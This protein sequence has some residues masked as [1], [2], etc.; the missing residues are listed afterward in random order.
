[1]PPLTKLTRA[2]LAAILLGLSA[3]ATVPRGPGGF[4]GGSGASDLVIQSTGF[5]FPARLGVFVRGGGKQYDAA[6]QDLSVKYKAG[7]LIIADIYEYPSGGK[8][9]AAEF[10]DRKDE[11]KLAHSDARL[12]REGPVTIHPGGIE[13][14]GWKAVFAISQGYHYS[15]PP[16][17]QSDLLVLQRG[18]RF[19]EYRFSYSAS[20]RERA[21]S[22]IRKFIDHLAWP[23]G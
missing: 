6:G 15:F 20:H 1:M 10:A 3:C 12:L 17:Y 5:R 19:I 13:R 11:I 16:P 22:E 2:A 7:E 9:L 21:E 23:S 14:S 8:T 4:A 18:A